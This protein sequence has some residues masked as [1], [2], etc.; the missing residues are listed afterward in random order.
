MGSGQQQVSEMFHS[1]LTKFAFDAYINSVLRLIASLSVSILAHLL[2]GS[3]WASDIAHS[4]ETSKPAVHQLLVAAE[5]MKC[6][7]AT[8]YQSSLM[9]TLPR[10]GFE[11][12]TFEVK[13]NRVD[14]E[15]ILAP[16]MTRAM[17]IVV[18]TIKQA[19]IDDLGKIKYILLVGGSS[20]L[21]SVRTALKDKFPGATMCTDL[22]PDT[23]VAQG[24]AMLAA[25]LLTKEDALVQDVAPLGLGVGV[26][27]DILSVSNNAFDKQIMIILYDSG[28]NI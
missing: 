18:Q 8:S 28:F 17:A 24:A 23:I 25:Q 27:G 11:A 10:L 3:T 1:L 16:Y 13:L 15:S 12:T 2:D 9:I 5:R 6:D 22:N 19:K 14:L 7:L 4:I 26:E 21:Q 20:R